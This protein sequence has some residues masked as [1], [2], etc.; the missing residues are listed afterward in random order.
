MYIGSRRATSPRSVS[1]CTRLIRRQF[2]RRCSTLT[3]RA[4]DWL[5]R[6]PFSFS[7]FFFFLSFLL[8]HEAPPQTRQWKCGSDSGATPETGIKRESLAAFCRREDATS[9]LGKI[10][11]NE[12]AGR[13]SLKPGAESYDELV[14]WRTRNLRACVQWDLV[15]ATNRSFQIWIPC[16]RRL[17]G[18]DYLM[19]GW[20]WRGTYLSTLSHTLRNL[21]AVVAFR[22]GL[23]A[24]VYFVFPLSSFVRCY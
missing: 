10:E 3:F 16:S 17:R 21:L 18:L 22:V 4:V 8:F 7:F 12:F 14:C 9:S 13:G 20:R 11:V 6:R 2:G 19:S 15:S 1:R 24:D 23:R 5:S